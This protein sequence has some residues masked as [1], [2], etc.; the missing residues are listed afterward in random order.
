M[1][2]I[3]FTNQEGDAI[4][5]NVSTDSGSTPAW[6]SIIGTLSSQVDLQNALNLKADAFNYVDVVF[7]GK[8]GDDS[9]DGL[10]PDKAVLTANRAETVAE[11]LTTGSNRVLIQILDAGLYATGNWTVDDNI[12]ISG[13][14]A[15]VDARIV[16]RDDTKID[17]YKIYDDGSG[18]PTINKNSGDQNAY[19]HANEI[20]MRGINGTTTGGVGIRNQGGG[21]IL[22]V[23]T[24][25]LYVCQDGVG[26][27][28]QAGGF[29]HVH[30]EAE[31]L[32]LA[33]NNAI[34]LQSLNSSNSIICRAGHILEFGTPTGT[35]AID[36][37]INGSEIFVMTNE[38]HADTAIEVANGAKVYVQSTKITGDINVAS[39]GE[40]YIQCVSHSGTVT[41]NGT[42]Q[43]IIGGT[44]YNL[45]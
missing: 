17:L 43:G 25:K 19:L 14:S 12:D 38:I 41:N 42:I 3:I 1:S 20:D 28:D 30:I 26:V 27:G 31:D 37:S 44:L 6:G 11:T 15:R 39:G 13:T 36:G 4:E 45:S 16:I 21:G 40:L 5:F 34:G 23:R 29:G 9:N 8:H 24:D 33:G 7:L 2:D 18:F 32:Y 10:S 22:V 35:T